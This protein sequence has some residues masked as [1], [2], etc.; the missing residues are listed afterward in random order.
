MKAEREREREMNGFIHKATTLHTDTQ[1]NTDTQHTQTLPHDQC[2]IDDAPAAQFV[3]HVLVGER[4][5]YEIH[6]VPELLC[7]TIDCAV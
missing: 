3:N 6:K 1:H 4:I 5:R 2:P 7:Q